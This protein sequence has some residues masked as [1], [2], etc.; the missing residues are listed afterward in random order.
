MNIQ[1]IPAI[2]GLLIDL[3]GTMYQGTR[4]VEGADQLIRFL[5][6]S[7]IAYRFVTNNSSA[8][9]ED[10]AA[11][12]NGMGIPAEPQD[13]CTSGQAAAVYIAERQPG[14]SVF[15]IGMKGLRQALL[16]SGLQLTDERP[17]YVVQGIDRQFTYDLLARAVRHIREGAPYILTNP[18]LLV[19]STDG[20]VPGAG[21][22]SA[23]L[24]AASGTEP[25]VIGK[26]SSILMDY[27][28]KQI[29]L[30]AQDTWVVGDN[31]ATDI[32]AGKAS[33]CGTMLVLTGLTTRDNYD[34]YARAAGCEPD[35]IYE[36]LDALTEE[37]AAMLE[38]N[39]TV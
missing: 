28:L 6:S 18:D 19:P 21:S 24:R 33:G 13:V 17:D 31:L 25:I 38:L 35:R 2:K 1:S 22:I 16:D 34:G 4:P 14:A 9:P 15:V 26:P 12:L 20:L 36:T 5:K 8:T 7:N 37:I 32:A 11:R 10:V 39:K 29:G 3:D 27:A 30:S 23:M